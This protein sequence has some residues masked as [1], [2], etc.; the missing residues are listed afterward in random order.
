MEYSVDLDFKCG[1][2]RVLDG[3]VVASLIILSIFCNNAPPPVNTKPFSI[4]SDA[5]S[6]GVFSKIAFIFK[7]VCIVFS[8]LVPSKFT[9]RHK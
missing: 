9:T 2:I 3:Y 7:Q 6:G 4:K 8:F 1:M 5:S